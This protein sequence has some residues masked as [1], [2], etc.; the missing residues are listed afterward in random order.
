MLKTLKYN[1][2]CVH[3][4]INVC[5]YVEGIVPVTT[6]DYQPFWDSEEV[7]ILEITQGGSELGQRAYLASQGMMLIFIPRIATTPRIA[8]GSFET[9]FSVT[10]HLDNQNLVS[11]GKMISLVPINDSGKT[12]VGYL[13]ICSCISLLPTPE[14]GITRPRERQVGP[15]NI[16]QRSLPKP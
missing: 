7:L 12:W 16:L 15:S 2:M 13:A 14:R 8:C 5:T 9:R 6:G 3:L 1:F 11:D 4:L 10:V